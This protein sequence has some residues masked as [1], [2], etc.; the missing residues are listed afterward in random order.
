MAFLEGYIDQPQTN[1][2][3]DFIG[4]QL[5]PDQ[6]KIRQVDERNTIDAA[7]LSEDQQ[8]P[9]TFR[10]GYGVQ[11]SVD[12][13]LETTL[14]GPP[15]AETKIYPQAMCATDGR[16]TPYRTWPTLNVPF[17]T[18][19]QTYVDY[20]SWQESVTLS[21]AG[22]VALG[23]INV[24]L[25]I[26]GSLFWIGTAP[27]YAY[28]VVTDCYV[29]VHYV[30]GSS[31]VYRPRTWTLSPSPTRD[32]ITYD[33][34]TGEWTIECRRTSGL[35]GGGYLALATFAD[36]DAASEDL[37]FHFTGGFV[38]SIFPDEGVSYSGTTDATGSIYP[39]RIGLRWVQDSSGVGIG[40]AR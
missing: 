37:S 34:G 14:T 2:V 27:D 32:S 30:D 35:S 12:V 33:P 23:D 24:F 10:A 15:A 21:F 3:V 40:I 26:A 19:F 8:D 13:T 6:L 5:D 17:A 25:E 9:D 7:A 22:S 39:G 31:A 16:T 29:T 28:L 4:D 11:G 38:G 18:A 20:A 1:Y 36:P